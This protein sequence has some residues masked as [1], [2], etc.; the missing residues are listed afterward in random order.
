MRLLLVQWLD[1]ASH[2]LGWATDAEVM[3]TKPHKIESVG[4]EVERVGAIP[5]GYLK[6]VATLVDDGDKSGDVII[7]LGCILSERELIVK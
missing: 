2:H 7:P 3:A 4:W 6:L 5:E 1:A